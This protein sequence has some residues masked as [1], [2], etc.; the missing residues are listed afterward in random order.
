MD[1][2]ADSTGDLA[3]VNGEL[4]FVTGQ[5]AIAQHIAFRLR[6]FL[7]ESRYNRSEGAPWYQIL[8]RPETTDLSRKSILTQAVLGTPGVTGCTL[9]DI[10][11][12]P[13]TRDATVSGRAVTISGEVDFSIELRL[14]L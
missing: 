13:Q 11:A 1:L 2:L 12:D 3:I 14:S 6:T 5:A 4:S 10:V 8:F 7:Q 9:N